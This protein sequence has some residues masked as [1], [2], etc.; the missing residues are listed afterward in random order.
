MNSDCVCS[1][2]ESKLIDMR[3]VNE[4]KKSQVFLGFFAISAQILYKLLS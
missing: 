2:N 4:D 3:Y 1:S